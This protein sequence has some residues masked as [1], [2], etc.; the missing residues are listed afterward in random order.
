MLTSALNGAG[1]RTPPSTNRLGQVYLRKG[2][3]RNAVLP[4]E[5][6]SIQEAEDK[7]QDFK[8]T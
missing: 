4:Q 8:D 1:C 3:V 2:G 6:R 5:D 7:G